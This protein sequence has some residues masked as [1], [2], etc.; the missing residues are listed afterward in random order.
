MNWNILFENE[1][2]IEVATGIGIFLLFLLFRKIFTKYLFKFILRILRKSPDGIISK[3]WEAFEKPISWLFVVIGIY[4]SSYFYFFETIS[5][6]YRDLFSI[7]IIILIT[8]GFYNFTG[9]TSVIFISLKKRLNWQL[10]QTLISL[11]SN[12]LRFIVIS[13][14][15]IAIL[16][17]LGINLQGFLAGLG[18]GGLAISLAAQ[19]TIKNLIGGFVIIFEKTFQIGDWILTPSVEG[20]VEEIT[21]RSTRIR[22]FENALVTVPNSTLANENITNW[23]KMKKR[24]VKFYL[25]LDFETP[26]EKIKT[27]VQ[28]IKD[29]LENHPDIHKETIF[30]KF[31]QFGESSFD[32]FL[33]FFTNTT[34]WGE[35][36]D[37]KQEMNLKILEILAEEGIKLAYPAQVLYVDTDRLRDQ[38][39]SRQVE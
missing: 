29:L 3:V 18:L 5:P 4:I 25:R 11:L 28:R 22:T 2:L 16:D 15:L 30:V 24:R 14:G 35:Y 21:L 10:D 7:M 1:R 36:L 32:L 37:I 33:Y 34:V 19:D 8:W 20:T 39:K 26:P 17:K 9:S 38:E 12:S 23:S 13:I 27:A 31:D 6:M